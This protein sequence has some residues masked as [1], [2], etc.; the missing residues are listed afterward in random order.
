MLNSS[1]IIQSNNLDRFIHEFHL[2]NQFTECKAFLTSWVERF[3]HGESTNK[4]Q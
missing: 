4:F 1:E 3:W 2:Y